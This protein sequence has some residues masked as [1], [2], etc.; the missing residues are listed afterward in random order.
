MHVARGGLSVSEGIC[1]RELD[2]KRIRC[3]VICLR[4]ITNVLSCRHIE[5]NKQ[6]LQKCKWRYS[7]VAITTGVQLWQLL[8]SLIHVLRREHICSYVT[9]LYPI[10]SVT[11]R[12]CVLCALRPGQ[13]Q[14][15]LLVL[16]KT[17]GIRH[18]TVCLPK[19]CCA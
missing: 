11:F 14:R 4:V 10:F 3:L 12:K 15:E 19:V 5:Q 6:L 18:G 13:G 1:A 17:V 2:V 9:K 16:V 8:L 7:A